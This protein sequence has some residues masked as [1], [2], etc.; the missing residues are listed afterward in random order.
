MTERTKGPGGP[1]QPQTTVLLGEHAARIPRS[2]APMT[3]LRLCAASLLALT[4]T[5]SAGDGADVATVKDA[6]LG[7]RASGCDV[8]TIGSRARCAQCPCPTL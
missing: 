8:S 1:G 4:T 5:A 2:P 7:L 3:S 6:Y